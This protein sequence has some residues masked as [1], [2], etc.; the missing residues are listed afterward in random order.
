MPRRT[1]IINV[2]HRQCEQAAEIMLASA[3]YQPLGISRLLAV[4]LAKYM[5]QS[6][7]SQIALKATPKDFLTCD[8]FVTIKYY[9]V[10]DTL[11]RHKHLQGKVLWF[12]INGG[13][14]GVDIPQAPFKIMPT[15]PV[16]P[17]VGSCKWYADDS[18]YNV[19][20][21]RYV[22]YIP[23]ANRKQCL[24]TTRAMSGP[25]VSMVHNP[26]HWGY[27]WLV[28]PLRRSGVKF[29]GGWGAPDSLLP[30]DEVA[31]KL[32][33]SR[34]YIHAKGHDCPG[35]SLYQA[36]MCACPAIITSVFLERTG[37]SDLYQHDKTC[38]VAQDEPDLP[39]EERTRV[40]CARIRQFMK[41]LEDPK[42]NKRIG[43]AGRARLLELLWDPARE[44][45]TSSFRKFMEA[46]L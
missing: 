43:E 12:D 5:K 18:P 40:L 38:L 36:L 42:E 21:P 24:E 22:T 25:P 1:A 34:C 15:S 19:S 45:D 44:S 11:S 3:G 16:V 9:S 27:G 8:L 37:Y 14:P 30:Q 4:Q 10:L 7:N 39:V 46:N 23:L 41:Q 31:P 26:Y 29:H 2:P 28:D 13:M 17:Y 32:A 6:I 35:F 33:R 20:G